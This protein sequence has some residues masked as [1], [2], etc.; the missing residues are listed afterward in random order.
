[1]CCED[2][3]AWDMFDLLGGEIAERLRADQEPARIVVERE[4]ARWRRFWSAPQSRALARDAQVGLM[5]ELLFLSRWLVDA[6]GAKGAVESWRG[7]FGSR[8]D[9]EWA[10]RSVEVK[11]STGAARPLFRIHGLEQL[12]P[13]ADGDL[14]LCA[15]WLREEQGADLSLPALVREATTI[16]GAAEELKYSLDER[17]ALAG[18]FREDDSE[19]ERTRYRVRSAQVFRVGDE[20]PRMIP[21]MCASL[22][23]AVSE[24]DY[25][26]AVDGQVPVA[27][28][29]PN[30]SFRAL[31]R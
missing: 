5:G 20:F 28:D 16:L 13:P 12:M 1:V 14:Y 3:A 2:K 27:V 24:V 17:L 31:M 11:S 21:S 9:F 26:I 30:E 6:L 22:S 23:P 18:Y 8:H 7:P 15:V 25:S 29:H 4:L 10:R 19:Y